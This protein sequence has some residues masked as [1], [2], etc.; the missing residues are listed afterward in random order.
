MTVCTYGTKIH[1]R[2]HAVLRPDACDR[3]KVMYMDV[4]ASDVSVGR[5]EVES[6]HEANGTVVRDAS[7]AGRWVALVCV[8]RHTSHSTLKQG[9]FG[10][11]DL[12][13]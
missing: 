4:P 13:R 7:S 1:D 2:I 5:S 6:T 12:F 8:Y 3:S 9:G 11:G 10:G